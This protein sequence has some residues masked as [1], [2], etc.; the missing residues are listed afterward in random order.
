MDEGFFC[1]FYFFDV[2][3]DST[4]M[5]GVFCSCCTVLRLSSGHD[6]VMVLFYIVYMVLFVLIYRVAFYFLLYFLYNAHT[7]AG[8]R[9][10]QQK[11][12][13]FQYVFLSY[14]VNLIT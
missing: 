10:L 14:G 4:A 9:V 3:C 5:D 7:R 12:H 8:G 11:K 2:E 13:T 6:P 1:Y